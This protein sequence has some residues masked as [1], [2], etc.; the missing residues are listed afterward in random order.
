M[1]RRG[2]ADQLIWDD[3]KNVCTRLTSRPQGRRPDLRGKPGQIFERMIP[4][5]LTREGLRPGRG[6]SGRRV[7]AGA[8]FRHEVCLKAS[9]LPR[10]LVR[11]AR[12][13]AS[14]MEKVTLN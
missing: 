4:K 2:M 8:R 14:R 5:R 11:A 7:G 3:D 12:K 9:L 1:R 6:G 13:P 10:H